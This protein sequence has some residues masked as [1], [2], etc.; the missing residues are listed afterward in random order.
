[1]PRSA[2][3]VAILAGGQS[4]RMGRDKALVSWRGQP[5]LAHMVAAA[6]AAGAAE[7][8]ISGDP[9]KYAA[10]GPCVPDQWPGCG[11]LG[12]IASVLRALAQRAAPSSAAPRS[13]SAGA[14]A[15]ATAAFPAASRVLILACDLPEMTPRFLR[16]LWARSIAGG[17][18]VPLTPPDRPEPLCAVYAA[19]LLPILEAALSAG[20]YKITRALASAPQR[21]LTP[22]AIAAA[23]F[24]PDL[25]RNCNAPADLA[26]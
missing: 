7:I 4:R 13:A 22:D 11:P 8:I 16:W 15:A 18:T 20:D 25:F 14:A 19:A 24:A 5:L 9:A 23:G 6:R 1:M 3:R 21:R 12:G 2:P 26:R 17:W 10:F